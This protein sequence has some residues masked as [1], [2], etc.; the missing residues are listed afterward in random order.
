V[1]S[2][3]VDAR[4]AAREKDSGA[5]QAPIVYAAARGA[6]V[7]D[8]DGNRY[9]DLAAGFGALLLGHGRPEVVSAVE[10]QQRR[11]GLALGDVYASEAKVALCERLAKLYPRRALA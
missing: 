8:A 3:S 7:I 4:R 2:P 6:N 10:E 9:V 1:E 11:L 5:E